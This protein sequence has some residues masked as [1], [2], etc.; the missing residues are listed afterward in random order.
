M[1][2]STYRL[3]CRKGHEMCSFP[4]LGKDVIGLENGTEPIPTWNSLG[5]SPIVTCGVDLLQP[6]PLIFS[7][8]V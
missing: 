3:E 7:E 8:L 6:L 2:F 5:R 1:L 4:R